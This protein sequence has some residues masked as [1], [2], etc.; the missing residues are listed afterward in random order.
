MRVHRDLS[1]AWLFEEADLNSLYEYFYANE[2]LV[3]CLDLAYVT[4]RQG[5]KNG[6]LLPP[7]EWA[8]QME[9]NQ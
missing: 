2:L 6:L 7:G 8:R 9:T 5:F 1:M 3:R 4:D